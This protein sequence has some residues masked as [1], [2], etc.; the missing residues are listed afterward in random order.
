M[1]ALE[2]ASAPP[3]RQSCTL[4]TWY[5]HKLLILTAGLTCFMIPGH[6]QIEQEEVHASLDQAAGMV[7]FS[8]SPEGYDSFT[9]ATYLHS[10]V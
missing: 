3:T 6:P 8:E 5:T 2:S 7:S 9:M 4:G 1:S 10:Q